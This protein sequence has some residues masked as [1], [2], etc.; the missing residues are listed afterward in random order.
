MDQKRREEIGL[1]LLE[2]KL[3]REGININE[4]FDEEIEETAREIGV[5]KEEMRTFVKDTI[6]KLM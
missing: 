1:K 2:N 3:A 6:N 4:N 5:S